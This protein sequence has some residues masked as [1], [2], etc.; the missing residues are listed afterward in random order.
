MIKV[1]QENYKS[2]KFTDKEMIYAW[3]LANSIVRPD[4]INSNSFGGVFFIKDNTIKFLHGKISE[5]EFQ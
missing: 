3:A 2:W 5:D 1:F 4:M